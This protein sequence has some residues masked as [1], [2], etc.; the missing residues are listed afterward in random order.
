MTN[1]EI[2]EAIVEKLI[3]QQQKYLWKPVIQE[4]IKQ[5]LEYFKNE[6]YKGNKYDDK[7][8]F[9]VVDN[10][11]ADYNQNRTLFTALTLVFVE[12][13][14]NLKKIKGS[15]NPIL[16]E[17]FFETSANKYSAIIHIDNNSY[18]IIGICKR[19]Q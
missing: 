18:I 1:K 9:Y 17:Q 6:L 13:K 16:F 5:G 2:E 3:K 19:L 14:L 4:T 11:I 15:E 12:N 10:C 8:A 7:N